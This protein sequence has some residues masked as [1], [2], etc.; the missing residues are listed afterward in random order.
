LLGKKPQPERIRW[1]GTAGPGN[2]TRT[3]PTQSWENGH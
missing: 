2:S 3:P 1:K